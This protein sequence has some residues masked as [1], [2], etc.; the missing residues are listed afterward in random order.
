VQCYKS[1]HRAIVGCVL[2]LLLWTTSLWSQIEI[3]TTAAVG[4]S[5]SRFWLQVPASYDPAHPPALLVWWHQLG[6]DEHEMRDFTDFDEEA[7]WRGW[8]AASHFGWSDRHWNNPLA[9]DY[10]T[11]MLEWIR[12]N[13]PFDEDSMYFIGG[14]MGGAAGM[15]YHNN[16]CDS[17]GF[18]VAATASGSGIMDCFRRAMEYLAQGDT[19]QS[20]RHA[21][22]G[23]PSEAPFQYQRSSAIYFADTTYS[24]HFNSQHLPVLLTFGLNENPWKS[25]ALD[26]DSVRRG[27]AD[28]TYTFE[29]SV[30]GHGLQIMWPPQ[31]CAWLSGFRADRYPDEISINADDADRYYW[32][33]VQPTSSDCTFARFEARKNIAENHLDLVAIRHV[34]SLEV[35]GDEIGLDFSRLVSGTWRNLEAPN[36]MEVVLASVDE[37]PDSVTLDGGTYSHWSYVVAEQKVIVSVG[38]GGLFRV[39][40]HGSSTDIESREAFTV[41]RLIGNYPN[42]FN[43]STCFLLEQAR[44]GRATLVIYNLLGQEVWKWSAIMAAGT[45]RILFSADALTSGVYFYRLES[46][47]QPSVQR[48]ILLR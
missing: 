41:T 18:F 17:H 2:V 25:H 21:F 8:L 5:L 7:N 26:L 9:Q 20:M 31:I 32:I 38:E 16:H 48:M 34:A 24:M 22:G 45:H 6:G 27:W 30:S 1:W 36:E 40:P 33:Q 3:D 29:S 37:R 28:T 13:Y 35:D 46:A 44:P 10:A 12:E 43:Q 39:Y 14:S 11:A 47:P 42:P 15:V 4:D 19:N 23:L